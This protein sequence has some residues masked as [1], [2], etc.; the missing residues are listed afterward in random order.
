M[1]VIGIPLEKLRTLM[2][3]D[4]SPEEL[5]TRLGHLGCDVE[6]FTTLK[7]VRCD[8]CGT[9]IEMTE[10]EDVPPRCETCGADLR[11]GHSELEPLEV[12]RMELL[13]VRPDMFDPG[14]L[15]RVLRGYVGDECGAP[16]YEVDA[17]VLTLTV[18]PVVTEEDS[19]RPWIACAVIEQVHL[20]LDTLKIIM[21]LQE[22]LHWA[23]GR[24]RKH[25][26]IGVY[27][28]A[29]LTGDITYTAED[30]D[31]FAFTPLGAAGPGLA[32]AISLRTILKEHPKGSAYAHLLEA[33]KR[34]PVLKDARGQVLS[35]PPVINSEATKVT[36]DSTGLFID[37]TG[38]GRRVVERTLNIMVSSVLENVPGARVRAVKI[39]GPGSGEQRV[40][41]DFSLQTM[42][43]SPARAAR[44]IGVGI[45]PPRAAELLRRMRH[46]AQ[47]TGPD[48]VTVGIPAYRADILHPIDLIEDLA[49]AY[50]YH[51]IPPR[52]V[53]T[54]TVGREH[55]I[56]ALSDRL[57]TALQGLG[58]LE[59]MTL[60]LTHPA[61]HDDALGRPRDEQ[62]V[63]V[64]HPI[65]NEQ[66]MLRSSLLPGLLATLEHN[67]TQ[68]LPQKIF[69]VGDVTR[70][71]PAAET[72]ARERRTFAC[73]MIGTRCGFE[74][75][76]A[77]AEAILRELGVSW[78]LRPVQ[79]APFLAGRAAEAV[80]I[81]PN[82]PGPGTEILTFGEIQPEVLLR[83]HLQN[84]AVL[85][86]GDLEL[87]L[88]GPNGTL[89]DG[90][91]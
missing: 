39:D 27:D 13:A 33:L 6:G 18:D 30:P 50:G 66:T 56:E 36:V 64:A 85:L 34:Y 48:E 80:G 57:R 88:P 26:S 20:D 16:R 3:A 60:V 28:L 12:V 9:A 83:F 21:K 1:P 7:R 10:Q 47:V 62:V 14:G 58:F 72:L 31:S 35:M 87:F 25:A 55:P 86:E 81:A 84:P 76:K 63:Q 70:L 8:A 40:T 59:V 29:T 52:L 51:N 4:P 5:L 42:T 65:S 54:F 24:N 79:A 37:V 46:D 77:V 67:L 19:Y 38:L 90:R 44:V 15:A 68:P 74:D 82:A 53:P 89:P 41:P 45:D 49:I 69:E 78:E 23:V 43:L 73:A 32:H 17:P 75:I 91:G 2:R 71:D 61:A 11:E 22:N